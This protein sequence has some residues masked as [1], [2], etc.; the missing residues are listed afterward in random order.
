MTEAGRRWLTIAQTAELLQLNP[1]TIYSMASRGS[2]P[3]VRICPGRRKGLRIDRRELER[4]L[5]KQLLA[6]AGL[7]DK[8]RWGKK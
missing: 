6:G 8:R 5:E 4:R 3:V 7:N 1:K 2:L